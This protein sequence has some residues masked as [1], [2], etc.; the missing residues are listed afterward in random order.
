MVTSS[1]SATV[2]EVSTRVRT[3]ELAIDHELDRWQPRWLIMLVL[4]YSSLAIIV[5]RPVTDP[6]AWWHLRVGEW[7]VEHRAVPWTDPF[8]TYGHGRPW[9]AYNWLFETLFFGLYRSVG[10]YGPMM[11]V[12]A[13]GGAITVALQRFVGHF[14]P[15][16]TRA[17]ALTAVGLGAMGSIIMPRSYLFSILFF[18]IELHV[19]F[20]VRES[21]RPRSLAVLP[22]L[23]AVWAN[24]HIQF[25]YGLFALG[26]AVIESGVER[27]SSRTAMPRR[28]ADLT[29]PL[30]LTAVASS[31]A[32]LLNPYHIHLHLDILG[33]VR[34]TGVFDWV[35]E[36]TAMDFRQPAH[37]VVLALAVSGAF[38]LGRQRRPEI[39]P[40]LLFVTSAFLAFR[41]RRDVWVVTVVALAIIA[42][43]SS[44]RTQREGRL[45][46]PWASA[47]AVG[48]AL[49]VVAMALY[50]DISPRGLEAALV[51]MYP[52]AAARF[53][54]T[55][56]Y[57][58]PLY[59]PYDWGG[60]LIWRLPR[61]P[62]VM[63][64]RTNL[65]GDTRIARSIG[66][67]Q[68]AWWWTSD[69]ELSAANV[70][71]API[72][73]GLTSLL[74]ADP[75]FALVY[76]DSVAAVFLSRSPGMPR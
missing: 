37:W 54:E 32:T 56:A 28:D 70:V 55:R 75:R 7:I 67:W 5:I 9:I 29:A 10:L 59:N 58:G 50:R 61:L 6:D 14:D 23:F 53:V 52:V 62:V 36:H 76:E 16:F 8:S 22:L 27:F 15:R 57:E 51:R 35:V 63:D 24:V 47:A 66:T 21:R 31:A 65:H 33:V 72:N 11:Y 4:V 19:L 73:I 60:Y 26:L 38:V 48:V 40:V 43:S 44:G 25:I 1:S 64:G 74:R 34:Q 39:F 42:R 20:A 17:A 41:A 68:G 45:T 69:P 49:T 2:T 71:I 13:L 46:W 3:G 12:V 30:F 18:I